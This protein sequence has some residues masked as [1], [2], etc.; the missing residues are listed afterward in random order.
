MAPQDKRSFDVQSRS[1][2]VTLAW[3]PPSHIV[4]RPYLPPVA[5]STPS[6]VAISLVPEA[7]SGWPSARSEEHPSELQSLM[8]ISSA[9]FCLKTKEITEHRLDTTKR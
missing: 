7:P 1:M 4:C 2:I 5:S 8:R 6:R 3:P 9:V